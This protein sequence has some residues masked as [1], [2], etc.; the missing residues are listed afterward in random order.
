MARASFT[1]AIASCPAWPPTHPLCAGRCRTRRDPGGAFLE[2]ASGSALDRIPVEE[3]GGRA[4]SAGRARFAAKSRVVTSVAG[5]PRRCRRRSRGRRAHGSGREHV[6]L[7]ERTRAASLETRGERLVLVRHRRRD[8]RARCRTARPSRAR[9]ARRSR[10]AADASAR[11]RTTKR[12]GTFASRSET[13]VSGHL[14]DPAR[15]RAV[16]LGRCPTG[17]RVGRPAPS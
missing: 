9:G 2:S 15:S 5:G 12:H 17:A 11:R 1:V 16:A 6:R 8:P 7:D 10:R 3:A 13:D 4:R 14:V